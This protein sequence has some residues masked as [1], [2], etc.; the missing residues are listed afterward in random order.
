[1]AEVDWFESTGSRQDAILAA[2][3][4]N[5]KMTSNQLILAA[6]KLAPGG[7][8][9]YTRDLRRMAATG[10]LKARE[11]GKMTAYSIP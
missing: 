3:R 11:V 10:S 8:S 1:V 7:K 6:R 5:G 9:A 4:D 2:L